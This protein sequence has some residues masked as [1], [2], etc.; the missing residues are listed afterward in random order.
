MYVFVHRGGS[1]L[2]NPNPAALERK[3][4]VNNQFAVQPE[5][6]RGIFSA[7]GIRQKG[8]LMKKKRIAA[9]VL[10]AA[11]LAG[12]AQTPAP[13]P[14]AS[15][16]ATS[17]VSSDTA[18][19]PAG[20]EDKPVV[21]NLSDEQ[22]ASL[23]KFSWSL[24]EKMHEAGTDTL[25]SPLSAFFALGMCA[26]GAD[27]ATLEQMENTLGVDVATMNTLA[28]S[29]LLAAQGENKQLGI[30]NS[31]WVNE[32]GLD[33]SYLDVIKSAYDAQGFD[34]DFTADA[35][36]QINAWV[37]EKTDGQI[38]ELV[39]KQ[40]VANLV[41]LL[42]NTLNFDAKWAEPYED[43]DI[44]TFVFT[45]AQGNEKETESLFSK[46]DKYVDA[47]ALHGFVRP[48]EGERY[49]FAALIPSD[50]NESLEDALSKVDQAQLEEALAHTQTKEVLATIPSFTLDQSMVLN[51][52]LQEMGMIDA[53]TE[54][55]DFSKMSEEQ[56][57]MISK[58]MQKTKITVNAQGTKAAAAT[59]VGIMVTSAP[60]EEELPIYI[61]CDRP[62][63]Y[64][65]IDQETATP[66]FI[67]TLEGLPQTPENQ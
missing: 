54:H 8:V 35:Y 50:E 20:N 25:V 51:Q 14:D 29:A 9:A 2:T 60:L 7:S 18:N 6:R 43:T 46:E 47:G 59:S 64:M 56:K 48:Y 57:L 65:I 40:D 19:V 45:D 30:A 22:K 34:V 44:S 41:A 37:N 39:N 12:C 23:F 1:D 58:V 26:N 31:V 28:K 49:A 13:D 66:V 32:S 15:S 5:G 61:T 33:Q 42:V 21:V 63:V 38:P 11:L 52:A 17:N 36:Q 10:A 55:A 67:G 24:F 3:H 16:T 53:F 4:G 62:F 27:G